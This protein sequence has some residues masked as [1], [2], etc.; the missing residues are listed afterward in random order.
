MQDVDA[1]S[2]A[3]VEIGHHELPAG[4]NSQGDLL[5]ESGF[6]H[7]EGRS[8]A[9][10]HDLVGDV[11]VG[12]AVVDA[13][14]R[15]AC[16]ELVAEIVHRG[17]VESHDRIGVRCGYLYVAILDAFAAPRAEQR[18]VVAE[19]A[20]EGGVDG[21]RGGF[22]GVAAEIIG[23]SGAQAHGVETRVG[24]LGVA[25]G[26]VRE[27]DARRKID[28]ACDHPV[29]EEI[30]VEKGVHLRSHHHVESVG[31]L[32][33]GLPAERKSEIPLV[34]ERYPGTDAG[35]AGSLE[36]VGRD[37]VAQ[38]VGVSEIVVG[39]SDTLIGAAV[40]PVGK[41][42]RTELERVAEVTREREVDGL[43]GHV[44]ALH[45]RVSRED[46]FGTE[47][48]AEAVHEAALGGCLAAAGRISGVGDPAGVESGAV[49]QSGLIAGTVSCPIAGPVGVAVRGVGRCFVGRGSSA[50]RRLCR[51]RSGQ[52]NQDS[53]KNCSFPS[54]YY[55]FHREAEIHVLT[56]KLRIFSRIVAVSVRIV[57]KTCRTLVCVRP[58][59]RAGGGRCSI[60][61]FV[62]LF[63]DKIQ[64]CITLFVFFIYFICIFIVLL[65]SL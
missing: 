48:A 29:E 36:E 7:Y 38:L 34:V 10:R 22:G 6:F 11:D 41:R 28:L 39:D 54:P 19:M 44:V 56:P 60:C 16:A 14:E 2:D 24:E 30:D 9:I 17:E 27:R 18:E 51:D 42:S 12:A 13:V 37:G 35:D 46:V 59:V 20:R 33:V 32:V 55:I 4:R 58:S 15:Y 1:Q 40:N 61:L 23:Q 47:L 64:S 65:F 3:D 25:V 31:L 49:P 52:E 53:R 21:F 43:P 63:R 57:A 8:I 45:E 26:K 62:C 5:V 50:R